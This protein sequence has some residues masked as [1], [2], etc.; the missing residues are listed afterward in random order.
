MS[1]NV[2]VKKGKVLSNDIFFVNS[3]CIAINS[4]EDETLPFI[5]NDLESNPVTSEL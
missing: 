3:D 1:P 4:E 5:E 2:S